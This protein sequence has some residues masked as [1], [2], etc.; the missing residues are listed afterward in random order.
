M[1]N[2]NK[3]SKHGLEVIVMNLWDNTP[4]GNY[5]YAVCPRIGELILLSDNDG[6]GDSVWR[7]AQV[8][9]IPKSL[10][11]VVYAI[12]STKVKELAKSYNIFK[13]QDS[14]TGEE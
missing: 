10:E 2:S 13:K 4:L 9:H 14:M 5:I 1:F 8:V 7:V 11:I 12:N 6:S 3:N